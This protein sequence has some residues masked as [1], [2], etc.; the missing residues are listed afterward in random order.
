[1]PEVTLDDRGRLL[2]DKGLRDKYGDK[3]VVVEALG[4]IVLI[5]VP[6]DPLATLQKEGE[7]L[8]KD[9]SI[10]DLKK[11]AGKLAV[12]QAIPKNPAKKKR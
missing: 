1:M 2:L 3:F 4:E 8:P 9:M 6:K 7:K 10:A 12:E 11:L 5:P